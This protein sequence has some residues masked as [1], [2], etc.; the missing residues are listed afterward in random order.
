MAGSGFRW[1]VGKPAPQIESHSNAKLELLEA[2]LDRYFETVAAQPQIDNISITLV[3]GFSGGGQYQRHGEERPGSPLV[4]LEAVNRAQTRLNLERRKPLTLD[5]KFYFVDADKG[6][7]GFLQQTLIDKGYGEDIKSGR[8]VLLRGQFEGLWGDVL[9]GIKARQR[10]GR[11]LFVLD[12][13]GW[14]Q[15]QFNTIRTILA[16]LPKAEVLLTFAVDWLLSYLNEGAAFATAMSKVGF[17]GEQLAEYIEARGAPG[18]QYVIPR[19]LARDIQELTGAPFFTPFFLR[20]QQADRDLWLVHLSKIVTAR[21]VMVESHWAVGNTSQ[22]RGPAGLNMLGFHPRWEDGVALDFGFDARASSDIRSAMADEMPY[23]IEAMEKGGAPTVM[24]FIQQVANQTAATRDQI[25]ET[26]K[27]L[28]GEKQIELL[29]SD[30][31]PRRRSSKPG[32]SDFIRLSR[33]LIIPGS[34]LPR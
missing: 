17:H 18:Y 27:L 12:Q 8:I 24:Q 9:A 5:A 14:N 25:E 28:H 1:D 21:N 10:V 32:G 7:I 15:V 31:A 13:K 20:S 34:T 33:Q 2:Y 22:H 16:D 3:D 30:G 4:L 11:S 23:R 6:A 19:L 26:I 29:N